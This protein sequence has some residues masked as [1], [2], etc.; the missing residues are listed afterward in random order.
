MSTTAQT[1]GTEDRIKDKVKDKF[2][3]KGEEI[4]LLDNPMSHW[5]DVSL[6]G[7]I[8]EI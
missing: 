6:I 8:E 2:K 3:D 5:L 7:H 1:V 4:R